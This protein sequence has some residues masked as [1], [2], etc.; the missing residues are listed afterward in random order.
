MSLGVVA[1]VFALVLVAELPDKTMIATLVMGSRGQPLPVWLGASGAFVLHAGL[2]AGAGRLLLLLP[3]RTIEIVVTALFMAG[4][5]FLLLVPEKTEEARGVKEGAGVRDGSWKVAGSAFAVIAVG[6]FGDLT[7]L[8]MVNL[9]GRYHAPW[10]VFV[11]GLLGLVAAASLA[12][13][14]GRF[15]LRFLP[16]AIIRRAAG[17]VLAGF[18]AYGIFTLV[19]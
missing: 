3:H 9:V 10:S 4:A 14:G 8:L 16:L 2:A 19:Q 1:T 17:V 18:G 13:F 11:G 15:L 7:Q 5:A 6:E 12:A